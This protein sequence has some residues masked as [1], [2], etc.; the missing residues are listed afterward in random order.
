MVP[1]EFINTF[2]DELGQVAYD[3]CFNLSS[4]TLDFNSKTLKIVTNDKSLKDWIETKYLPII[5]EILEKVY[6]EKW[7][8]ELSLSYEGEIENLEHHE[9]LNPFFTFENFVVGNSNQFA[10][11]ASLAVAQK[12]GKTYNPL[13]I[14]GSTGLGKTHLMHAIGNYLTRK[15][16]AKKIIYISSEKFVNDLINS[17]KEKKIEEF[18]SKY[19]KADLV[20]IDDI[21]FIV[22]KERTQEELFHTF[23]ELYL[24]SKQIVITSDRPPK[25]LEGIEDRLRSRFQG[26][27]IADVQLP[28]FETR[29]AI[30]KKK[31]E[32]YNIEIEESVIDYLAQSFRDNVRELEGALLKIIAFAD[33]EN[34]KKVSIDKAKEIL[35]DL[36]D[37]S[38]QITVD[39]ILQTVLNYFN[40]TKEE[41]FSNSREKKIVYPRQIFTYLLRDILGLS[42]KNI[43]SILG[44]KDHTT[45][46]HAYE[47][48]NIMLA[49]P[50]VYNDIYSI[51]KMLNKN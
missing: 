11:A 15:K 9:Q 37:R 22:G 41:L 48:I 46:M 6:N 10:Y 51:K 21:Q 29:K 50:K 42:F 38:Q 18:R 2:I 14:Y 12:P 1:Q 27:L 4:T 19:R 36:I 30:V 13:F 26:G 3:I 28:D 8:V 49:S 47:K 25:E 33:I 34:L 16:S 43:G 31:L 23:N 44:G 40:L 5:S 45:I 17:I 39:D 35:K 7:E 24:S 32:K 20:L